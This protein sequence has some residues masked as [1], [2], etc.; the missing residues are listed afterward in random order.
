MRRWTKRTAPGR[1][2]R[3]VCE[4]WTAG[5]TAG[6]CGGDL[7]PGG[8]EARCGERGRSGDRPRGMLS[9]V[10][11]RLKLKTLELEVPGLL[12]SIIERAELRPSASA[13]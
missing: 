11:M 5:R 2:G 12:T 9:G 10:G 8:E 7:G 1:W 4:T 6:A 13:R 3:D